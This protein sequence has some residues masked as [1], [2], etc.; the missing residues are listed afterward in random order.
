MRNVGE[1]IR[2][3]IFQ[4]YRI[5]YRVTKKEAVTILAIMQGN[6]LLDNFFYRISTGRLV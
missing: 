3:I 1:T 4:N 2:E 6:R 5:I